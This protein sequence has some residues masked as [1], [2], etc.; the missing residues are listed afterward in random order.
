MRTKT[1]RGVTVHLL[2]LTL[3]AAIA[4]TLSAQAHITTPK[5]AF[6]ANLG[7]DYSLVNYKQISDY[8]RTLAKQSERMKLVEIGKTAEGRPHFMAIVTSPENHK[9]LAHYKDISRGP[10]TGPGGMES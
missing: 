3:C 10:P 5:E 9:R 1:R 6:G 8:W 2:A 4:P 7:D